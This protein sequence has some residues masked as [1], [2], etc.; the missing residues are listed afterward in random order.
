MSFYAPNVN[1]YRRFS[2]AESSPINLL[3]GYDNR[4][5]G[6]RVP[7]ASPDNYRIENRCPGAD[8]N[9]LFILCRHISLW[10][11]GNAA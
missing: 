2:A 9:P 5:T 6:F 7:D 10:L 3:W 4:T 8:V 1:S 11:F